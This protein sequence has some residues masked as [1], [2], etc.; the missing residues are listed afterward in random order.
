MTESAK[1]ILVIEDSETK[2]REVSYVLSAL[3]EPSLVVERAA[4]MQQANT[5]IAR[6]IWTLV[7]L[8]ISMDIR[9]S[10]AGPGAGGHDTTGGLKIAERMF[11]L[12]YDAPTIIVTAFDAFPSER[13]NRG[14][15]LGLQHVVQ[16]AEDL[17]GELMIG[18]VRYGDAGWDDKLSALIRKV[19]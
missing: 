2:W 1:R 5:Q 3:H 10:T 13:G 17:L 14:P 18:W 11:Y 9:S 19:L 7:L 15:V 12:G 8:D 4:T 16:K 6:G